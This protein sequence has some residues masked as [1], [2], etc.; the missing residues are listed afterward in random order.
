MPRYGYAG[1]DI[2]SFNEIEFI[3]SKEEKGSDRVTVCLMNLAPIEYSQGKIEE[4][5]AQLKTA[6]T[7]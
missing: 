6:G 3:G 1:F 2:G 5:F 4:S 7:R